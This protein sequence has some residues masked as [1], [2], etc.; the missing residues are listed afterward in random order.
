MSQKIEFLVSLEQSGDDGYDLMCWI[1]KNCNFGNE[2]KKAFE[3]E[4]RKGK[5]D[6]GNDEMEA[7]F[8]QLSRAGITRP[9]QLNALDGKDLKLVSLELTISQRLVLSKA[10]DCVRTFNI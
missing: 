4:V 5:L 3:N 1:C 2:K 9:D 6:I 8:V 10:L 7:L